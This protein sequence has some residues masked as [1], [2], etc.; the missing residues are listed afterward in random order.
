MS[1]KNDAT[2]RTEAELGEQAAEWL[3]RLDDCDPDDEYPD[4]QARHQ[5][6]YQWL[7]TSPQHLRVFLET[8]ETHRRMQMLDA[9]HAIK[10]ETLLRHRA[11]VIPLHKERRP[12][13]RA[14]ELASEKRTAGV[15]RKRTRAVAAAALLLAALGS[16]G[17]WW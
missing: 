4:E 1:F 2:L 15:D 6:F 11:D 5:A 9:R 3:L 17:Y 12:A 7:E 8:V 13:R 10:V 16:G 14:E